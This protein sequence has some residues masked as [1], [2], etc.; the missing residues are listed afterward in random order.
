[1]RRRLTR[2]R[3]DG[4]ER[5]SA[6]AEYAVVTLAACAFAGLLLTILRSSEVHGLLFGLIRQA[7]NSA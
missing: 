7:L 2:I 3:H 6:T 4:T 5:G 1:M